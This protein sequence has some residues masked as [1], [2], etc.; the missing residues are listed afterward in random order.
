MKKHL[1]RGSYSVKRFLLAGILFS[2]LL[3]IAPNKAFSKAALIIKQNETHGKF[4]LTPTFTIIPWWY[5][6]PGIRFGI[7]VAK[8]GFIPNLNDEVKIEI[9]F[10]YQFWWHVAWGNRCDLY[11]KEDP[12]SAACRECK[13]EYFYFDAG[14]PIMRI[15]LPA[16]MRWEFYLTKLVSV[17]AG[18][19]FEIGIPIYS[20]DAYP[21]GPHGWFW[22]VLAFGT[23][24]HFK[25][26][27][28]LRFEIGTISF[29]MIGFEFTF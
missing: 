24:L 28:A 23:T 26:H 20:W 10:N 15:G 2:F 6:A 16:M 7:P 17:Y 1:Y 5:F 14:N 4:N 18:F 3:G 8:S 13:D 29:P 27:F 22:L 19:G 12:H 11:C 25:E 21:F 9:G